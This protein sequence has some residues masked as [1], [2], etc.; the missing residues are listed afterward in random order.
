MVLQARARTAQALEALPNRRPSVYFFGVK[1]ENETDYDL[2]E[3][4]KRYYFYFNNFSSFG[5]VR[6]AEDKRRTRF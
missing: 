5:A 1:R 3:F 6:Q 2:S 4:E